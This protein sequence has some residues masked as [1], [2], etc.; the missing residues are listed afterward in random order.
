MDL[1]RQIHLYRL[2]HLYIPW[3]QLSMTIHEK[4]LQFLNEGNK[5]KWRTG[6]RAHAHRHGTALSARRPKTRSNTGFPPAE[7]S[8]AMVHRRSSASQSASKTSNAHQLPAHNPIERIWAIDSF[9]HRGG[10]G[11]FETS[12]RASFIHPGR[13]PSF[14]QRLE[15]RPMARGLRGAPK[16]SRSSSAPGPA[17]GPGGQGERGPTPGKNPSFISGR[18][19]RAL[20]EAM[21]QSHAKAKAIPAQSVSLNLGDQEFGVLRSALYIFAM[22]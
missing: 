19:K 12:S 5:K 17:R 2:S 22:A 3:P 21:T 18:P 6:Q 10:L 13:N 11:S 4:I 15:I 16:T 20:A 8:A 1:R 9:G 7:A 14:F